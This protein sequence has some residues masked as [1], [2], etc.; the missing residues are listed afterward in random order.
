MGGRLTQSEIEKMLEEA[1]KYKGSDEITKGDLAAK[2]EFKVYMKRVR[3]A[4]EDIDASKIMPPDRKRL[5]DKLE[6][7]DKWLESANGL[8][9]GKQDVE[10]MQ[11]QLEAAMNTVMM[12]INKSGSEFW[13][14]QVA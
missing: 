9:A 11:K 2:E 13:N 8:K 4:I 7:A 14:E 6:E 12:K 5:E 1:E 3:Q 10:A